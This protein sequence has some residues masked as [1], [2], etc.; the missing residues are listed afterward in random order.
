MDILTTTQQEITALQKNFFAQNNN[1]K[2]SV[3]H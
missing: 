1:I 2:H 3:S